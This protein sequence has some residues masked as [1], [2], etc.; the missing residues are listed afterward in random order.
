MVFYTVE[1]RY[2]AVQFITILPTALQWRQEN[3]S[4]FKLTTDTPY[5]AL[6]GGLW[7]VYDE[8]NLPHYKGAPLYNEGN[9]QSLFNY[10]GITPTP[11]HPPPPPPPGQ[12]GRYFADD[13]FRWVFMNEMFCI[14]IKISL[15]S[16][17]KSLV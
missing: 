8:E 12:N 9:V 3:E 10:K 2:N 6:M 11:P 5:L 7:G 16:V 4:D 17:P 14:L 15:K 1:F 13:I